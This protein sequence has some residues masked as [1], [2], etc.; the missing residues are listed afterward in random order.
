MKR[1][2][3]LCHNKRQNFA[4]IYINR[5]QIYLGKWGSD[6][7]KAAYTRFL[8]EWAK[9]KTATET[10]LHPGKIS[11]VEVVYAFMEDFRARPSKSLSDLNTYIFLGKRI[12]SLFP[13]YAADDFR[14][15]DLETLRD[16]FQKEGYRRGGKKHEYTRTYLN[17]LMNRAKSIFSWGVSKEMVSA[18]TYARLKFLVPLRRGQTSA[19][20]PEKK[21]TVSDTDFNAV[22]KFLTPTYRDI[23]TILRYTGMRPS[24]LANMRVCDIEKA[25][26]LWIY[27]PTEHK[28]AYRGNT[29]SIVIGEKAQKALKR[30]LKNRGEEEYVFTP[31]R[32]M[33]E[34]WTKKRSHRKSKVTPSQIGRGNQRKEKRTAKLSGKLNTCLIGKAVK[35]ACQLA[36]DAKKIKTPWT[37]YELRHT[38]ITEARIHFGAEAAQHFAGHSTIHTQEVYDHSAILSASN[39][40]RELG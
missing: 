4:Y 25:K 15:R 8:M 40:A 27:R 38:A 2:P 24:E 36:L 9:S 13:D 37:P 18:E 23:A 20:E 34:Y 28:T 29:R 33:E 7:A 22:L 17:K 19:P 39:V 30:H 10:R 21:H 26:E 11:L 1:P 16:S 32:I 3:K 6:E 14:I 31:A 5:K 35:R 12:C